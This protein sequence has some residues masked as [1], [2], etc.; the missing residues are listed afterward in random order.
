MGNVEPWLM[1][2]ARQRIGDF[3]DQ[4]RTVADVSVAVPNL[5]WTVADL[6]QHVAG[7]PWHFEDLHKGGEGFDAPN[8]WAAW[9]D[10][11][12]AHIAK[13]G[14][15]ALA[16]VIEAEFDV[17]FDSL[18]E[19][20]NPRWF[21]GF[22]TAPATVAAMVVNEGIMHG[23]D[24]AGVTGA[25][26]PSF[27]K[28]EAQAVAE[29]TMISIHVFLD[30]DKLEAQPDGVYHVGFRGGKDFSWIKRGD[31]LTVTEGRPAKADAHMS[32][33]PAMFMLSSMGRVGQVR[34]ALSGKVV[35]YGRKPWRFLGLTNTIA[36]GV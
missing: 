7:L 16:D 11:R 31:T 9:G 14:P 29:A 27:T 34:A 28:Q 33:D 21:Y 2:A 35:T 3:A 22:A 6:A 19:G 36:D 30:P 8:D 10:W 24:L 15:E 25:A 18:D 32:A 23:R 12:R 20:D 26:A 1:Q 5:D 13:T 4:M 17:L